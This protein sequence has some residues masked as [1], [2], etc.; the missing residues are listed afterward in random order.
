VVRIILDTQIYD[1]VAANPALKDLIEQH[2]KNGKIIVLTTHVQLEELQDI[3][4]HRD[5]GQTRAVDAKRTGTS[6]FVLDHSFLDEDRLGSPESSEAFARLQIG[7]KHTKDAMIG[8]T[9][10]TDA[11]I[12]VTDDA[13]FRRRFKKLESRVRVMSSEE[14]FSYLSA[15]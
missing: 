14:F 12:L 9:A 10:V 2:C 3:P 8:A 5:I 4:P 1:A 11:D 15:L 6:V 13:P 7:A